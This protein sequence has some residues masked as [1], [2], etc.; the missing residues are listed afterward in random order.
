MKAQG[1]PVTMIIIV[2]IGLIVLVIMGYI[3][4]QKTTQFGKGTKEVAGQEC[5]VPVGTPMLIEDCQDPVY[6]AFSNVRAD[7]VCCKR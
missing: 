3:V 2:A 7:Q 5:K 6:G 1:L 4:S